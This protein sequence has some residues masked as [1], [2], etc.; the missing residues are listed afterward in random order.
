MYLRKINL[1]N[2]KN[3][4]ALVRIDLNIEEKNILKNLRL[5]KIIPTVNLLLK[6]K[7]KIV[8]LSHFGRPKTI[9]NKYSLAKF[10]KI[11]SKLLKKEVVFLKNLKFSENKNEILK[12][13]KNNKQIFL[14]ENLRF[15]K[16]E[17]ENDESFS[18]NLASLGD[19]YINEA[20]SVSHR[21]HASVYSIVKYLP[22]F[23]GL[24]P[25]E[26]IINLNKILNKFQKPFVFILGGAKTKDKMPLIKYFLKKV[27]YILL[28]GG[29]A[30]TF[31]YLR[32]YKIGDSLYENDKETLNNLK[33]YLVYKKILTP[34]DFRFYREQILDIGPNTIL[35][36][37]EIIK[38]A[39]SLIFNGPMGY[40]EKNGFQNGTR[41]IWQSLLMNKKAHIVVGGGETLSS[42]FL[43]RKD[44]KKVPSNI[45]FSTG[46]G[47]MLEYLSGK[48]LP[49]LKII[50]KN[51]KKYY[52]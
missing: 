18:K 11:L 26:E 34:I 51:Y 46:G 4:I 24:I 9:D 29:V 8:F 2:F 3:K 25:E 1:N 43:V 33:R 44:F 40:F 45:F 47:A 5:I 15:Y 37:Q 23:L 13:I 38:K 28:G 20:F 50:D 21:K 30:N 49:G 39:K 14:L 31:L 36:Y 10:Q 35:R 42:Y 22:S 41:S 16:E 48:D 6:N 52:G 12:N 19:F 7:I 32:G 17:E 27:D